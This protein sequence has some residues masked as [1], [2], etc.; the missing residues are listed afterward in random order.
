[1]E[2]P[3]RAGLNR[4][5]HRG[6]PPAKIRKSI[7]QVCRI[8]R[9]VPAF[10]GPTVTLFYRDQIDQPPAAQRVAD[11]M[12]ARPHGDMGFVG[13]V[14]IIAH[15]GAPRDLTGE[16]CLIRAIQHRSRA[17]VDPASINDQLCPPARPIGQAQLRCGTGGHLCHLGPK[18]DRHIAPFGRA[19][20][21]V[22]QIGAVHEH[23]GICP[24]PAHQVQPRH[25]R[26]GLVILQDHRLP[27]HRRA[28]GQLGV[29]PHGPQ[30]R[31]TV[32]ADLEAGTD[33]GDRQSLL[34][35][36]DSHATARQ[37]R[38]SGQ[39]ADTPTNN[40]C[41]ADAHFAFA[42]RASFIHK[43]AGLSPRRFHYHSRA[44]AIICGPLPDDQS[45]R[46]TFSRRS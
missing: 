2:P 8:V 36:R 1:M 22:H 15:N 45:S 20:Q 17:A 26:P 10:G 31:D 35:Q 37:S 18:F 21:D 39:A 14:E 44:N 46:W 34:Q 30:H 38:C 11:Q 27:A 16:L 32:G 33:L 5:D 3:K 28:F 7:S 24:L 42:C 9:M 40:N 25:P 6:S 12:A 29:E 43:S 41:V 13:V 4:I 23:I 19:Q